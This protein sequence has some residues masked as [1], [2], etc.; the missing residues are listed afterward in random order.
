[1]P[2]PGPA[3]ADW[4][5][6][7]PRR[8][9]RRAERFWQRVPARVRRAT[10]DVVPNMLFILLALWVS[11]R[12]WRNP[13]RISPVNPDGQR[14]FQTLLGDAA[15][16]HLT[17]PV[18]VVLAPVTLVA[19]TGI[20]YAAWI[21]L[22]LAG[23]A[24]SAYWALSR[25]LLTSR[26]AAFIGG[27]V[28]GFAPGILWHANGELGFVTN[29]LIPI[30]VVLAARLG[31]GR[32]V[33]DGIL[34]GVLLAGQLLVNPELLAITALAGGYAFFCYRMQHDAAD[35][36]GWR[37]LVP[38]RRPFTPGERSTLTGLGIALVVG[39][40]LV[41]YPLFAVSH[42][43]TVPNPRLGEDATTYA[44]YWRDTLAGNFTAD[45]SI[46]RIEQNTWFGWPLLILAGICVTAFWSRSVAVRVATLTALP[47]GVLALGAQIRLNGA[48][49][50]VPGPWWVLAKVPGF[51]LIAPTH[52]ALVLVPCLAVLL[53]ASWDLVPTGEQLQ[54]GLTLRRIWVLLFA[55]ALIPNLPRPLQANP[56]KSAPHATEVVQQIRIEG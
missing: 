33:R 11:A 2:E 4:L 44:L 36:P 51:E 15:H 53:A 14:A 45:R 43:V 17:H 19:G 30:I 41:A 50:P 54:Y 46:G 56:V 12:F 48:P 13:D 34:L 28:F 47:F 38:A 42:H 31:R 10:P 26:I 25:Y 52:L 7:P 20:G 1:M 37:R 23:S 49:T 27:L 9:V 6:R 18:A 39:F 8:W 35:P 40:V 55:V 32:P 29:A 16:G 22:G 5:V 21:T 3:D 24:A